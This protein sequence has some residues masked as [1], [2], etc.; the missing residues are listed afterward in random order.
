MRSDKNVNTHSHSFTIDNFFHTRCATTHFTK[1][2]IFRLK[3]RNQSTMDTKNFT[4]SESFP[5][6][7]LNV[8][9]FRC[10]IVPI[11]WFI[12]RFTKYTL[13]NISM[14]S[15]HLAAIWRTF[16][17]LPTTCTFWLVVNVLSN[18]AN[19]FVRSVNGTCKQNIL[20]WPLV[21]RAAS[22][23]P[24]R[25]KYCVHCTAEIVLA[26]ADNLF[27]NYMMNDEWNTRYFVNSRHYC[28]DS[29]IYF[30]EIARS[31][32]HMF[33]DLWEIFE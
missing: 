19:V 17:V 2:P 33:Y 18:C 29:L 7:S 10:S 3:F 32:G 20:K 9:N 16:I 23:S 25:I 11:R 28:H 6:F 27:R 4:F 5:N 30:P 15:W 21:A 24:M 22:F 1:V 8:Q 31:R 13:A 26:S 12:E 14:P